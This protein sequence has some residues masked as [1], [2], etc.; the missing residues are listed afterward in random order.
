MNTKPLRQAQLF[1]KVGQDKFA[2]VDRVV[3]GVRMYV[4]DDDQ[5]RIVPMTYR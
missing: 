5:Q 2:P 1:I 3:P 4:W